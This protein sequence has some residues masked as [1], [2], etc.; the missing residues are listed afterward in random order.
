MDRN[1]CSENCILWVGDSRAIGLLSK[2][3]ELNFICMRHLCD[4]Q[5]LLGI[6]MTGVRPPTQLAPAEQRW[7]KTWIHS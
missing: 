7:L 1:S 6:A 4:V 5:F 2:M 3:D